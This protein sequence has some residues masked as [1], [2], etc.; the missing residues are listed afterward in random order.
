MY[1]FMC[2]NASA[3]RGEAKGAILFT[4]FAGSGVMGIGSGRTSDGDCAAAGSQSRLG[5]PAARS[6]ERRVGKE[7]MVQ[8]RSRWSPYH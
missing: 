7:C 3:G 1:T 4:R 2:D 8:C 5:L 6:G